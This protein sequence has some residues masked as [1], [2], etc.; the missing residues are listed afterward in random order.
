ML[1]L[2]I[3]I[4]KSNQ[5]HAVK[6]KYY[7]IMDLLLEHGAYITIFN[8]ENKTALHYINDLEIKNYI[9]IQIFKSII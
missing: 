6:N 5:I 4:M 9:F 7:N 2:L 8:N 1:I 3:K